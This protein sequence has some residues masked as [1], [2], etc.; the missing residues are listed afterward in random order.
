VSPTRRR[1]KPTVLSAFTGAGGLDLGLRKAG[2]R[3]VA[4][5]ESDVHARETIKANKL[6]RLLTPGD[7]V[8]VAK[9]LTPKILGMRVR[10]LSILAGAPPCQPFSKAAQWADSSRAGLKDERSAGVRAFFDLAAA[11]LPAVILIENVPGFVMGE[12][13]AL[14]AVEAHLAEINRAH[15]TKYRLHHKRL[16]ACDYGVPQ[17]RNRAILVALRDGRDFA[18]PEATHVEN[19]TRA[20]DA[21]GHL[22]NKEVS[23]PTG[24]WAGLLSS[25]PEGQ[26]YLFHTPNGGGRPLFGKR[27]RFW[28]FLLKLSKHEPSWTLPAQA[29]PATGPFHWTGRPL[30]VREMLRLQSFPASWRITGRRQEQVRQ[31]GNATPPL[32]AEVI[33][34]AIGE[35]VFGRE[36]ADR[37]SLSVPRAR[38][39]PP[40]TPPRPVSKE[41]AKYEGA[42][43]PH[44]GH[45]KGPKPISRAAS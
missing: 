20:Y 19:H 11:F 10:E 26:N 29:G 27:T 21:I 18:W 15:N 24:K 13:S 37:P 4:C 43:A 7:I 17:R 8:E 3:T 35:Q 34:R 22:K 40:A 12:T 30:T 36:Y 33:G 31:V 5:I 6:G 38:R 14:A 25:I 9:T 44:P 1:P 23:L 41:F 45:G 39:I 2:F 28:S 16:D 42:H 32:L